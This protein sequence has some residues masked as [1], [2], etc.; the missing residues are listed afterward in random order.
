VYKS[1][2]NAL[3]AI[4]AAFLYWLLFRIAKMQQDLL[5]TEDRVK[6]AKEE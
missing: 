5:Q 6:V 2:R 3:L 1:H 4:S